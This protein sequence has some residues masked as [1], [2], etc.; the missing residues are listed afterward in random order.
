MIAQQSRP[1]PKLSKP[2]EWSV[3]F[4]DF[5]SKCLVKDPEER[6]SATELL[7]VRF[8]YSFL[9]CRSRSRR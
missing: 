6:A 3:A 2:G 7:Q 8:S 4:N 1:P 5:I 9:Y